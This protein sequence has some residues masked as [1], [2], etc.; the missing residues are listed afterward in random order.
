M[1]TRS[2][3][4][5]P[6][7]AAALAFAAIIGAIALFDRAESQR[8]QQEQRSQVVAQASTTRARLEGF[9]NARLLL[10]RGLVAYFSTNPDVPR[11][12][13]N[14][15]ASILL[16][17]EEGVYRISGVEDTVLRY[18]YPDDETGRTIIGK[19]LREIPGQLEVIER[20]KATRKTQIA[21]PVELV[22]G[23][24]ALINFTP[25][26]LTASDQAIERGEFWGSVT[27]LIRDRILFE[28]VGLTDPDS[29]L[30]YAL[31]GRDGLGAAGEVFFGD[32]DLFTQNPALMEVSLPSGSWQLAA[33]PE[34]GWPL[35]PPGAVWWRVGGVL[36]AGFGAAGAFVLVREPVRLRAA[37][38]AA[39]SANA[40]LVEEVAERQRAEAALRESE[41]SLKTAKDAADAANQAKSE[42]LANMSHELRTPLNGIL[43]YAQILQRSDDLAQHRRGIGVI[44]QSGS[45][46]LTLIND[47]LDLAKIE[48]RK[49]ELLPRDFPLPAF[50]SSVVEIARIRAQQKGIDLHYEADPDL[51][52]G[53]C[54]DEKRLRQVL[55][56]LLGNA[57]KFTERGRVIL[58]VATV[59][60]SEPGTTP[61]TVTLRFAVQDTG[62][63]MTEAQMTKIFQPFEQVGNAAQCAE[64]T[65]L[66]LAISR[67]IVGLMGS[68]IQVSS[69]LG[70]GSK[71]WFTVTLPLSPEWVQAVTTTERGRLLGYNG[72]RRRIL[73]ADD[74]VLNR[75]VLHDLLTPLDFELSEAENGAIA[76]SKITENPPDLLLTDLVMPELDGFE[77]ARR[78]RSVFPDLP[79]IAC[80]ASVTEAEQGESIAA[81]CSEF[82]TKPVEF[83]R[84]LQC[85]TQ[86]LQLEWRYATVEGDTDLKAVA[87]SGNLPDSE[88]TRPPE[89]ELIAMQQAARIGDIADVE[90]EATRLR[91]LDPSYQAFCDRVCQLAQEFDDRAILTLLTSA[92]LG[93][94]LL[95]DDDSAESLTHQGF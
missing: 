14:A 41:A 50:L 10:T 27:L 72:R 8:F 88:L 52:S 40:Q 74:N 92:A 95:G 12:R 66:G 81:G 22:E 57:V 93:T 7:G 61:A 3:K 91:A 15:I 76:L 43:G 34:S 39:Q 23:G 90:A 54:A 2:F 16:S 85:L 19:D 6:Y 69:T 13:F 77:L 45:H 60:I 79:V 47:V 20:M 26:F 67:Q 36:L 18:S 58:H 30:A 71:F 46:L 5:L 38:V 28:Q 42:F 59:A 11:E 56:N 64:G 86:Y 51:P 78:V 49:L 21:G 75:Q 25:I 53:I 35:V 4:A 80:S 24:T 63:G 94:G 82:L 29:E 84:L 48:A 32:P 83:E 62:I 1:S 70:Q 68:E 44:Q 65:G 17:Q 55:L 89:S 37:I 33:V 87:S 31:R 73:V 9:L